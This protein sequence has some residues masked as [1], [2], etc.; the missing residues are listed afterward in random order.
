MRRQE[1]GDRSQN[2][3]GS[4]LVSRLQAVFL[5]LSTLPYLLSPSPSSAGPGLTSLTVESNGISG[6]SAWC[7][8]LLWTNDA[9]ATTGYYQVQWASELLASG[10]VWRSSW[11]NMVGFGY[12]NSQTVTV[13]TPRFYRVVWS[14]GDFPVDEEYAINTNETEYGFS[15]NGVVTF[16]N[17]DAWAQYSIDWVGETNYS[18]SWQS[19]CSIAVTAEQHSAWVPA[20]LRLRIVSSNAPAPLFGL[21]WVFPGSF[22]MG[23]PSS[24]RTVTL[25]G[26]YMDIYEVTGGLWRT[27]WEWASTNGYE[28]LPCI[29]DSEVGFEYP[30][31]DVTWYDAVKWCNARSEFE[32]LT[33]AYY[34]EAGHSNV[35]RTGTQDLT[36]AC[37]L[38]T[39]GF[40]LPTEAEWE[41]AARGFIAGG[42]FPWGGDS[43]TNI[44]SELA[45][46]RTSGD[47]SELMPS[48]ATPAGGYW[49]VPS[50]IGNI[51]DVTGTNLD[52]QITAM[53]YLPN[54]FGLYDMAGNVWEWCWDWY[55]YYPPATAAN[56]TGPDAGTRRAVRGGCFGNDGDKLTVYNRAFAKPGDR[57]KSVGFR[58]VRGR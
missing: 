18:R 22:Q 55:T 35:Y 50:Y 1:T 47:V 49:E 32:G 17:I 28:D 57:R 26:Y 33:P 16:R 13:H 20:R 23:S 43:A 34:L 21:S 38:V 48:R 11:T 10:T 4:P 31:A 7:G 54:G 19:L 51:P 15:S 58:C 12:T 42:H 36:A 8:L 3:V 24:N 53:R 2:R 39:N 56:P 52:W 5:L 14:N 44:S 37:M 41:R 46:Y 27:V 6:G 30:V 29:L 40:R 25:H 9:T 45:N